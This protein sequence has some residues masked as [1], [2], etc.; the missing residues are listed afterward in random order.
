MHFQFYTNTES[1]QRRGLEEAATR[2]HLY[3][4][5]LVE[6]LLNSQPEIDRLEL[7]RGNVYTRIVKKIMEKQGR[8][9]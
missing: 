4:T 2:Q 3:I 1:Y 5:P 7:L 9:V 8:I 6:I